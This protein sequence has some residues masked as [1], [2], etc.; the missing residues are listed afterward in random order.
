MVLLEA[1]ILQINATLV[2]QLLV[3]LVTL[4]VLY[5]VAWGPIVRALEA[6]RARIQEGI[7]AA[8][9]AQQE[10]AAAEQAHRAKLEEAR[11]EAQA[12]L[13]QATRMAEV[14]REDLK[15]KAK[16]E[17][18][19]IKQQALTEIERERQ[20]TAQELRRQVVDLALLAAERVIRESLD[21][22]KHRALIE[23]TIEEAEARA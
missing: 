16:Q 20:R 10:L 4:T 19:Q 6:R 12:L 18:G 15:G 13:E 5:R 2:A 3:F 17:A 9:R 8:E 1:G 22:P 14:L 7:E 11:R 21:S 23:R